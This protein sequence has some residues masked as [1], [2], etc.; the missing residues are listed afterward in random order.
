MLYRLKVKLT[1]LWQ[2]WSM[3]NATMARCGGT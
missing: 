1:C 3:H 2:P